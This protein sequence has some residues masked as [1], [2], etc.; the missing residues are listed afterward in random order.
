VNGNDKGRASP[1]LIGLSVAASSWL[2]EIYLDEPFN[3]DLKLVELEDIVIKMDT[4]AISLPGM[5]LQAEQEAAMFRAR[6]SAP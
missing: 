6:N 3:K 1:E 4:T 5:Q 2:L